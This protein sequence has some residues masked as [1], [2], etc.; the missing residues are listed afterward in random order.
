MREIRFSMAEVTSVLAIQCHLSLY[1][2]P[3]SLFPHNKSYWRQHLVQ[4]CVR[5]LSC[6]VLCTLFSCY[7]MQLL[8]RIRYLFRLS[9][10]ERFC[11]NCRKHFCI[12][13]ANKI[14]FSI[15]LPLSIP[16]W[17]LFSESKWPAN[18]VFNTPGKCQTDAH[19]LMRAKPLPLLL[20]LL[21]WPFQSIAIGSIGGDGGGGATAAALSVT[22]IELW[23]LIEQKSRHVEVAISRYMHKS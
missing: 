3:H 8:S 23:L 2:G 16:C 4:I 9:V 17:S 5:V 11:D 13:S 14:G 7:D 18:G 12:K 10:S 19:I 15:P 20:L 21:L 1:C 22:A 6:A